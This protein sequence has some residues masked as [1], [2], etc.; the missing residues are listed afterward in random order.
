MLL[1]SARLAQLVER[2]ALNLV[3]VGSSPTVGA[4]CA[5]ALLRVQNE[6]LAVCLVIMFYHFDKR[7]RGLMDK[8]SVFG[9]EDCRFESYRDHFFVLGWSQSG[10]TSTRCFTIGRGAKGSMAQR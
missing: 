10:N 7:S 5:S 4:F 2:K 8:A 6:S 3:V 1:A 9:T